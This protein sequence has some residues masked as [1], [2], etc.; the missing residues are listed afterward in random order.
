MVARLSTEAEAD[1]VA[2]DAA[3][4]P[5]LPR[6]P[7]TYLKISFDALERKISKFYPRRWVLRAK[8]LFSEAEISIWKPPIIKSVADNIIHWS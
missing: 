3:S 8:K 7:K 6:G 1:G 5:A 2:K 4:F